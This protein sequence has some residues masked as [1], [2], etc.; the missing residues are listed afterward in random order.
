M[1]MDDCGQSWRSWGGFYYE[2]ER[3]FGTGQGSEG[4][5]SEMI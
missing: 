5:G 1:M 3:S 2:V 4:R